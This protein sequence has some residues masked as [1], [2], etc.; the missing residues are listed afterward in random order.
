[1]L[2]P[3][4]VHVGLVAM[5]GCQQEFTLLLPV[6]GGGG[7][8]QRMRLGYLLDSTDRPSPPSGLL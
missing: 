5:L 4:V 2:R 7:R 6:D 3:D 8:E 1:M